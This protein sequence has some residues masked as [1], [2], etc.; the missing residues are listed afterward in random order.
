M[1]HLNTFYGICNFGAL[2]VQILETETADSASPLHI[3]FH[4]YSM[5]LLSP[6]LSHYV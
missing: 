2:R 1:K 3:I 5:L 4:S 6:R